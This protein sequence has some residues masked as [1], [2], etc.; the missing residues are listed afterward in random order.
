MPT[1]FSLHTL[2][3]MAILNT[4][5]DLIWTTPW[6]N[7]KELLL[8]FSK[9]RNSRNSQNSVR[10][11][12]FFPRQAIPKHLLA[13]HS[14]YFGDTPYCVWFDFDNS[15]T[16][17]KRPIFKIPFSRNSK[18]SVWKPNLFPRQ[19]KPKTL[20]EL[21]CL[22]TGDT[23]CR[24]W[25][26]L[27]NSLTRWKRIIFEILKN[28]QFA[29]FAKFRMETIFFP[30]QA[31]P[32]TFSLHTLLT[33]AILNTEFDLIWTSPW[34]DEKELFLKFSKVPNS[35]NSQNS[36]W[37]SKFFHRQAI[38]KH[39]LAL[40]SHYFGDTPYCVWF[41]FDNSLTRWKRP[42]FKIPFSRNSKSSVWKPNLFP[43]QAKPKTLFDLQCHFTGDTQYR[44]WFDW[45][46]SLTRW[47]RVIFK[48]LKSSQFA[49][50]AKFRMKKQIFS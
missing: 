10:K 32:T 18:S 30:R 20:F 23:Q 25:F 50:F 49:K 37:K 11:S 21:H 16:R 28:L 15:L 5:F 43:R 35:R 46:N 31:M 6:R 2:I 1:T 22:F 38:P 26:H 42:I 4:E 47:K 34:R 7:E 40:H 19:A 3:T 44:V 13:L 9:V 36:V 33:M 14:H 27:D 48:I 24:V 17:W 41:D 39:L 12:K 45:D 8:K 29:K